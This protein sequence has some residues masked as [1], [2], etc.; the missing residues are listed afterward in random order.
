MQN[1]TQLRHKQW[2]HERESTLSKTL[3]LLGG[4]RYLEPIINTAHDMGHRVV[5]C[6][7]LPDNYAHSLADEYRY[8]SI[9]DKESVLEVARS[10]KANGIMSFAADPGVITA[11]YVAERL[12]LPFQ[13]S[14]ETVKLLQ[15]KDSFRSFLMQNGFNCP[16]ALSFSA[17]EDV[18]KAAL[19][20]PYPVVVKPTD[21]AGSKGVSRVDKPEELRQSAEAA[22]NF[23]PSGTCIIEE[24]IE[25]QGCSSDSD[26]FTVDGR[27]KCVSFTDQLFDEKSGNPYAPMAY[28]MPCT[29]PNE[30]QQSI[31]RD[32]QRLSDLLGLQSGI[33]NIETRI[34]TNGK[35]YI[36]EI[37][38][39]GGG[40]RLAEMLRNASQVDLVAASVHAALGLSITNVEAPRYD[41]FWYQ[42]M[43]YSRTSG[44]FRELIPDK[45]LDDSCIQ[46]I[47]LWVKPGDDVHAFES[48]NHAI[49]SAFLRFNS[50]DKL[51]DYS[52]RGLLPLTVAVG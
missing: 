9:V 25:K 51:Q 39:R 16:Q 41:G 2:L 19:D 33:Y 11:S 46:E 23:S 32:L 49:G 47:Q 40:N 4:S 26:G 29:M 13:S 21:S 43:L 31:A 5:T 35:S 20:L 10:T 50:R 17:I 1:R 7:Y 14:Y 18:M 6:D 34:G 24:F 12:D 45:M 3:L 27:F 38:P 48:A 44:T 30:A 36:M 28:T 42:Q 37:S 52:Q 22:F 15:N 8:A